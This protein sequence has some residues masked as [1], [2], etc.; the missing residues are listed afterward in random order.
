M[1][2]PMNIHIKATCFQPFWENM[3]GLFYEEIK[4]LSQVA[5]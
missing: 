4:D 5:L 2:E 3:S 1:Y